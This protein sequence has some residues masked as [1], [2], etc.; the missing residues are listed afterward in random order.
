M[1]W[2]IESRKAERE[3]ERGRYDSVRD[4]PFSS[5]DIWLRWIWSLGLGAGG[6]RGTGKVE[7]D[8]DF[9]FRL[10]PTQ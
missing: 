2:E 6:S 5:S 1:S 4:Q 7:V 3:G 8:E 10:K 9:R